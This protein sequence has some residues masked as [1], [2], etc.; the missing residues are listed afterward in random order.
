MLLQ[1]QFQCGSR[2]HFVLN[3]TLTTVDDAKLEIKAKGLWK[4][5]F[6]E[7]YFD[8]KIRKM[9]EKTNMTKH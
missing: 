6:N 5:R 9:F 1:R 3:G 8:V 7:S 4:V 2:S